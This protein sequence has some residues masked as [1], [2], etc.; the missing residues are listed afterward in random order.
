M[1]ELVTTVLDV[2]GL[3][4]MAAGLAGFLWPLIGPLAFI[5]AG[6]F[7]LLVSY[8]AAWMARP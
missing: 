6:G 5:C 7:I 4:L 3:L 8:G 2:L 1:R